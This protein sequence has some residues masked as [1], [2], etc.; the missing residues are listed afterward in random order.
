VEVRLDRN[1]IAKALRCSGQRLELDLF[2][3]LLFGFSA[4]RRRK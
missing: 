1:V 3:G 2:D 4:L